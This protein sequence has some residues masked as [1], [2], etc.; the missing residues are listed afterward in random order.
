M[1]TFSELKVLQEII[2]EGPDTALHALQY[3]KSLDSSFA[4]TEI[5]YRI[6]IYANSLS[7]LRWLQQSKLKN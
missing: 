2:H 6:M 4:N 5:I 7:Q 1:N 3:V